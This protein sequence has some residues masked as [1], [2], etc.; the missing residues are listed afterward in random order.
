MIVAQIDIPQVLQIHIHALIGSRLDKG[1]YVY[2]VNTG[3]ALI[4]RD[5]TEA[6]RLETDN[7]I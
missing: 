5:V 3:H 2:I 7:L 6:A 4:G 1:V